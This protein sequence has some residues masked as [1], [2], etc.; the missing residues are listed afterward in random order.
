LRNAA[1][2]SA[3]NKREK[4]AVPTPCRF[5]FTQAAVNEIRNGDAAGSN[6]Y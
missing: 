4:Y 2:R 1:R 3:N 6:G 5:D